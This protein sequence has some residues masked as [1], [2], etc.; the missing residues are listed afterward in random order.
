MNA[1]LEPNSMTHL[2]SVAVLD[3]APFALLV[4]DY[5]ANIFDDKVVIADG[6]VRHEAETRAWNVLDAQGSARNNSNSNK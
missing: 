5:F 3:H 1:H 6:F 4:V 2:A